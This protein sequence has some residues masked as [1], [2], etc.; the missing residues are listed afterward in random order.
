MKEELVVK[1]Y[2][3]LTSLQDGAGM[4]EGWEGLLCIQLCAR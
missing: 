1:Q 4:A 2:G 3:Y